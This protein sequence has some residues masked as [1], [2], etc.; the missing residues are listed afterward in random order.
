SW[1]RVGT[2][3]RPRPD[4]GH[5][6]LACQQMNSTAKPALPPVHA[7]ARLL[8][9]GGE[10]FPALIGAIDHAERE[11][12]LETYIYADD[13]S[14]RAVTEALLR[15][16]GRGVRVVAL[17]DGFGASG[18]IGMLGERLR[19]GGVWLRLYRPLSRFAHF[20]PSRLRR[21]HRK[22]VT[23]DAT[24]SFVGGINIHD[25]HNL[26]TP[27]LAGRHDYAVAVSGPVV[28][29]L[30][31]AQRR[32]MGRALRRRV[33]PAPDTPSARARRDL[34]T[35]LGL[36]AVERMA[37]VLRDNLRHRH[38]IEHAYLEALDRAEREVWIANAY[39]VP[40][41]RVLSALGAAVARGVRVRLILQGHPEYWF[42][43]EAERALYD[44]L[45]DRGIEIIEYRASFLHAKVAVV[46]DRWATVG[47]SNLD[48]FSLLL[49]HEANV[50]I[51]DSAFASRLRARLA[52]ACEGAGERIDPAQWKRRPA[53]QRLRSRLV[54][55]LARLAMRAT[56]FVRY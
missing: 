46:D 37:L 12:L 51:E 4:H 53:W 20:T 30:R 16:A 1:C 5:A 10:F 8:E 49:A 52:A 47:S 31:H 56:G 54:Y 50:V 44:V 17:I 3:L 43:R 24:V 21:L 2:A 34:I 13:A 22:I 40:G 39:F 15:A 33:P 48:P 38:A 9:S 35:R 18:H 26:A 36:E 23:I 19:A 28:A 25:D 41:R 42:A 7:A 29:A 27:G 14:G 45:L 11:V 55:G 6:R 32:L